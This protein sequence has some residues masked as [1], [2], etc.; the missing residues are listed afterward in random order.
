MLHC[1]FFQ[2]PDV[3]GVIKVGVKIHQQVDARCFGRLDLSQCL[4]RFA[5]MALWCG[6]VVDT[7]QSAGGGPGHYRHGQRDGKSGEQP[8]DPF[9][10]ACLDNNQRHAGAQQQFEIV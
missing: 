8:G 7:L 1:N 4:L 10:I 2:Q 3:V 5:G 9:F 6:I